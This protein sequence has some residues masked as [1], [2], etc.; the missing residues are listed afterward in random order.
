VLRLVLAFGFALLAAPALA[1]DA[2]FVFGVEGHLSTLSDQPD[3]SLLNVTYGGALRFGYRQAEGEARFG[4]VLLLERNAW[5]GT[6]LTAGSFRGVWNVGAG[7][8]RIWGRGLL[9]SSAVLGV[10]ILHADTELHRRGTTGA[11]VDLRPVALRWELH[12]VL[13]F[14]LTPLSLSV[15]APALRDPP[16]FFTQY[17]TTLAFEVVL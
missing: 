1:D 15:L 11:F 12:P 9:R 7:V 4:G 6:E 8:E 10:S 3:R 14:E 5:L 2:P 17:R 16:L 13:T